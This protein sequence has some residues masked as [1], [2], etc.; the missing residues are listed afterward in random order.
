MSSNEEAILFHVKMTILEENREYLCK[1][2]RPM[3]HY[4]YL[5]SRYI[6][7][8]DDQ[9]LIEAEV[10]P[11]AKNSKFLDII[12]KK[13]SSAFETLIESLLADGTQNFLAKYLNTQF[14]KKKSS[15]HTNIANTPIPGPGDGLPPPRMAP[16]MLYTRTENQSHSSSSNA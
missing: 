1:Y 13:G 15:Y 9:H 16:T 2:L 12:L 3:D 7:N 8:E 5:R 11:K 10:T 4:C 14:E 6:L